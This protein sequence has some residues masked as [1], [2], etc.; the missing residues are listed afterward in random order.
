[1]TMN[2]RIQ[3]TITDKHGNAEV[4]PIDVEAEMPE[5]GTL[6]IDEVEQ[7]VLA[8][9]R[10]AIRQAIVAYLEELSKK[11]PRGERN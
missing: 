8:L 6:V 2:M 9:N 11:S 1:M 3:I 4:H 5:A 10:G 7:A